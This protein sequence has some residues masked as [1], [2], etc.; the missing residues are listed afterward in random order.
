[1]GALNNEID[2][3]LDNAELH[4]NGADDQAAAFSRWMGWLRAC[5]QNRKILMMAHMAPKPIRRKGRVRT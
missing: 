3:V 1:M 4:W 2:W 5:G